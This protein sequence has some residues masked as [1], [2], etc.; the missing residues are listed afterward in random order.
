MTDVL[1]LK[2]CWAENQC[3]VRVMLYVVRAVPKF[4]FRLVTNKTLR[5]I[6]T[7]NH[8]LTQPSSSLVFRD[9]THA[10]KAN[11]SLLSKGQYFPSEYYLYIVCLFND[12]V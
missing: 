5:H 6:V 10:V 4:D 9:A 7:E 8:V 3:F 2:M 12:T 1:Q 11:C